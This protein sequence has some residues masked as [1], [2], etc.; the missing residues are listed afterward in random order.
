MSKRVEYL[1]YIVY[2]SHNGPGV[3][4]LF[5]C[6][7]RKRSGVTSAGV[8][9]ATPSLS[10]SPSGAAPP[11]MM[12]IAARGHMLQPSLA[13]YAHFLTKKLRACTARLE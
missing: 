11:E 1:E 2:Y 3:G 9:G 7:L 4:A 6:T 5:L 12:R 10:P 13:I 8:R